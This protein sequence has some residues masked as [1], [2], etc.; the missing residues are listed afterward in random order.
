MDLSEASPGR[1]RR[2]LLIVLSSPSG[3]GKSTLA[4]M[5]LEADSEITMSVSAT[6]RPMRPG[7]RQDVDYHF[8]DDAE[9]DR[10]IQENE[11][12][13]WAMVFGYRY[14]TPKAPVKAALKAGRDIMFDI[15]WQGAR[16]LEPDFGEHLVTIFLLPPSMTE[17]ERRLRARATDSEQVIG[18]R[19]QRAADEIS[20]WAEYEYVLVNQ[21]MNACLDRVQAI[22]SAERAKRSSQTGLNAFV[23]D[24]I[25]PAH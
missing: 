4:R 21:D 16:Q 5:L 20:H 2:G 18:E 8:V 9:F 15:D 14:G 6:T 12:V 1:R 19:M 24:L 17:L 13:E 11:L 3:A 10:L 23:R 22:V 7:E 25:G